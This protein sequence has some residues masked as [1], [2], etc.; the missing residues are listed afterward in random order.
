MTAKAD[1]K[2]QNLFR[3]FLLKDY[4]IA[5]LSHRILLFTKRVTIA[6][7]YS[8]GMAGGHDSAEGVVLD[9]LDM[10]LNEEE[11][12]ANS[13]TLALGSSRTPSGGRCP[14]PSIRI[15][16]ASLRQIANIT[17]STVDV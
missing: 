9:E 1:L 17:E 2:V 15:A 8:G 10:R 13:R 7:K 4:G 12:R 3:P 5:A 16:C 14:G 6:Y 11:I